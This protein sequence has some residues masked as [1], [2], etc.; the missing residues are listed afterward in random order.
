MATAR[1]F[2]F[3]AEKAHREKDQASLLSQYDQLDCFKC[4]QPTTPLAVSANGEVTY[5]CPGHGQH[6]KFYWRIDAEGDMMYG[7]KGNRYYR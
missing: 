4:E 6:R 2:D 5:C 7:R 3:I 1:I